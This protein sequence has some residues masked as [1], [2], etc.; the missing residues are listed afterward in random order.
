MDFSA[1]N[2][3]LWNMVLQG[4]TI[5]LILMAA[6]MLRH[7]LPII[8]KSLMPMAVLG[9]FLLLALRTTGLVRFNPDLL[10]MITYHGIALG[11]I[12]LSLRTSR[13]D[14][15]GKE[16]AA[17]KSGAL[18]VSCY[19]LQGIIGLII[20]LGLAYTLMPGFFKAAGI[21]LPMGY[22]QGPGQANNIGTVY[23]GLGFTGGRSFGLAVAAAGYLS[24]C[25]VGVIYLN[26]LKRRRLISLKQPGEI[27]G[28]V[29]VDL[30]QDEN[31][32]PLAESVDKMS[33]QFALILIAYFLTYWVI[34]GLSAAAGLL[35]EGTGGMVSSLLWGFN[36]IVGSLMAMI[37]GKVL[38][39][40]KKSSVIRRQYQ[41]NYLLSRIAGLAFDL[42]VIAGIASINLPD[43]RGLWFPFALFSLSGAFLTLWYLTWI[44]KKI[45]RGYYYE[46]LVSMYGMMTGTI[47]S[48]VLLLRELDPEYQTPA[49][50]N[51]VNGTAVAILFGIPI[52]ALIG[53]APNSTA[54]VWTVLGLLVIYL[55]LLILFMLKAKGKPGATS[56]FNH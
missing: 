19:A 1:S 53:I 25:I 15:P 29:T 33:I 48:G 22:G 55:G 9:G 13:E 12:A 31:E 28:S 20:S 52:L 37:I 39:G 49:A 17:V 35:G 51:L 40:L 46:G 23:E 44:C 41:N 5:A 50:D 18:I 11:F 16:G 10:E 54:A 32:I 8:R 24:A 36:F 7:N 47:S 34:R 14:S 4:G 38:G 56:N 27:S 45:Y 3:L 2:T 21:L 26:I 42:M 6:N 43:L 30:F